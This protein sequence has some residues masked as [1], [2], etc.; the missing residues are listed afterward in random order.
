MEFGVEVFSAAI[1]FIQGFMKVDHVFQMLNGGHLCAHASKQVHAR[2]CIHSM[3]I[4][5][6]FFFHF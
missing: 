3:V 4:S 2:T 5:K 1:M 6:A